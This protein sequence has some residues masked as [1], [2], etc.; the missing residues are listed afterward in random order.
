[1]N[2][3]V[4]PITSAATTE[5]R[6]QVQAMLATG[7]PRSRIVTEAG[8]RGGLLE[9]WLAGT[10]VDESTT[11][12]L[13]AWIEKIEQSQS[14]RLEPECVETPTGERIKGALEF[15]HMTPSVAVI[16]GP[17]GIGK[18]VAASRYAQGC[19]YRSAVH[20]KAGEFNKTPTALLELITNKLGVVGNA[21]RVDALMGAIIREMRAPALVIIDEAQHLSMST[22]D[23]LRYLY[24]EGGIGL[25]L[26]GNEMVFTQIARGR[27]AMFA[28]LES[29]VGVY[30]SITRP[31]PGDLDAVLAAWGVSGRDERALAQQ[32]AAAPGALRVLAHVLRQASLAARELNR[33]L[34]AAL[35]RGARDARGGLQ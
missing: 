27:R 7:F 3:K 13:A 32:I 23:G 11:Q 16:Y 31:E 28:Q 30:L 25:A 24:D 10:L 5:L 20:V 15:A 35:M 6:K 29:R 19:A 26:V 9:Q 22:L 2:M 4:V 34:D 17:A 33:P 8:V 12:R 14:D 18:T 21:Y 1:M